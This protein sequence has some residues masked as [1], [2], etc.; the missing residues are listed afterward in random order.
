MAVSPHSPSS[1]Q[2]RLFPQPFHPHPCMLTSEIELANANP[3]IARNWTS[4]RN[5][6]MSTPLQRSS[7]EELGD[8]SG[9]RRQ[10]VLDDNKE[11]RVVSSHGKAAAPLTVLGG[12]AQDLCKLKPGKIL[13][14]REE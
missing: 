3:D 14:W 13:A 5:S 7:W 1:V 4:Y 9:K 6:S 2:A 8:H 10:K 11:S 12:H